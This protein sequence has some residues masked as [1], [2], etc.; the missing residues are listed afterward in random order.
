MSLAPDSDGWVREREEGKKKRE[1]E[2]NNRRRRRIREEDYSIM[3][4][5]VP[6]DINRS[7]TGS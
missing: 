7:N 1:R 3:Y 6:V 5:E 4:D 2:N